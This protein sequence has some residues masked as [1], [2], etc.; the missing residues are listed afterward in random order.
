MKANEEKCEGCKGTGI[1]AWCDGKLK[2]VGKPDEPQG[3]KE[4]IRYECQWVTITL[5]GTY[6]CMRPPQDNKVIYCSCRQYG[7]G[8]ATKGDKEE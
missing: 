5:E 4:P 2:N 6:R 8:Q 3:R 7:S 1:C